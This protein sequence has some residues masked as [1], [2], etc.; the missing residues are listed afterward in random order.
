MPERKSQAPRQGE[1]PLHG[2]G[3]EGEGRQGPELPRPR[4]ERPPTGAGE[5]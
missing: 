1:Q 2:P 4:T 5:A 3:E